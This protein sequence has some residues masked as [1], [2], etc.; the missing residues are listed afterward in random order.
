MKLFVCG[1][2]RHGK[3]AFA[4]FLADAAGVD[5]QS[6]SL[7]CAPV[8]RKFMAERGITYSSD[9]A[10]FESRHSFRPYWREAI[11]E[12][13]KDEPA[14]LAALIFSQADIYVGI[15]SLRE[16][17]AARDMADLSIWVERPHFPAEKT[18]DIRSTH[19]DIIVRNDGTLEELK[20]K[21][22]R[23]AKWTMQ[24]A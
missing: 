11:D 6:S 20:E 24:N 12:Y 21:A 19:C 7:M 17:Q 23:L 16:Y 2:G 18:C 9:L 22:E 14:R 5:F 13:N 1:H 10:C 8:V 15:R 4:G 3:D